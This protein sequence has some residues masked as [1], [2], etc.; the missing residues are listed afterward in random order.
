MFVA[1]VDP[2]LWD[3]CGSCGGSGKKPGRF[4]METCRGC[5]G[6]GIVARHNGADP[7]WGPSA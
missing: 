5:K 3:D 1:N 2:R 4:G 7:E 6:K